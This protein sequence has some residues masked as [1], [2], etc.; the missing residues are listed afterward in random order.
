MAKS[1]RTFLK[2]GSLLLAPAL[3]TQCNEL[4]DASEDA[5]PTDGETVFRHGVASGDPLKRRVILWTRVSTNSSSEN[6]SVSW[7]VF[8]DPTLNALELRG[9][10]VTSREVDYTVKVDVAGLMPGTTYYYRFSCLGK[11]SAVGRTRTAPDDEV[12]RLRFAVASCSN[13]P[14]GFFNAYRL[15]AN[16]RDLDAV[17]HLGD[18]LYEYANGEFGDGTAL[19]RVPEPNAEILSLADY[20]TRHAFYKTDPDLQE[21]HR[22]HPFICVWDDHESAND[23]YAGGAQNHQADEGD[24]QA[25]KEAAI[26]AYFEWM[27]IR[28]PMSDSGGHIYRQF[29]FGDLVDLT[30]LDTRLAGRDQQAASGCDPSVLDP[31]RQLLGETQERWFIGRLVN[32]RARWHLVGQQV[33]FGQLRNVLTPQ[34]CPLN[35]DQWDGYARSRSRVLR[36]IA[37]QGLDNVVVLTGDIHSSW[38]MDLAFDPFDP[39]SYDP[40]TGEGSHAVEFVTP[41][42]TSPAIDDPA[43]ADRLTEVLAKSHP[44]VKFVDLVNRGYLLLDVDAERIQAEWYHV[45]TVVEPLADELLSAI[46]VA[47]SGR[48]HLV[49]GAEPSPPKPNA[50]A[51]SPSAVR[52]AGADAALL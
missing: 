26:R 3:P 11:T 36:T 32:S 7:E 39:T 18:Y 30:M 25:R 16:R 2:H 28:V 33:M 42:V 35:P 52:A 50:P 46:Y 10:T 6:I 14:Y 48:N 17:L 15:I 4:L 12:E 21:V 44:H 1:R 34:A 38:A 47:E 5:S 20:R 23:A 31:E 51:P 40:G 49:S 37:M 45:T 24:W 22:Q 43:L 27:P 13:Y 9:E 41:G 19:G 8:S 29:N